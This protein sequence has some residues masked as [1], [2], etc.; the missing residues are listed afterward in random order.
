MTETYKTAKEI[1]TDVERTLMN[2]FIPPG[3]MFLLYIPFVV[4][5]FLQPS[6][7]WLCGLVAPFFGWYVIVA[8]TLLSK[9][10]Y[11]KEILSVCILYTFRNATNTPM[12][13]LLRTHDASFRLLKESNESWR[14]LHAKKEA[15]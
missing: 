6:L 8:V 11:A 4:G 10:N 9:D 15:I 14:N 7:W 2:T 13:Y 1:D 3:L 12:E 5:A